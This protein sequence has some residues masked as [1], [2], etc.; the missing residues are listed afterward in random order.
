VSD[1]GTCT[2][3]LHTSCSL[4]ACLKQLG[5]MCAVPSKLGT[6]RCHVQLWLSTLSKAVSNSAHRKHAPSNTS[7][8]I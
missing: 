7:Q 3:I 6:E 8:V 5:V 2:H 1:M 4:G